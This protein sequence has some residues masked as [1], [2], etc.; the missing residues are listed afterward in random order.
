MDVIN[1]LKVNTGQSG[2][3]AI[4]SFGIAVLL[5]VGLVFL[6]GKLILAYQDAQEIKQKIHTMETSLKEWNDKAETVNRA[7]LRPV[8][9][10]QVDKIQSEI[11]LSVQGHQLNLTGVKTVTVEKKNS[12]HMK[13]FELV[14]RGPYE[15]TVQF[16]QDF[17]SRNVLITMDSLDLKPDKGEIESSVKYTIY[18]K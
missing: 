13:S 15:K 18:T 10:S 9:A 1:V 5:V 3:S 6:S 16:L 14:T 17:G 8:D 12:N 11:I 2:R 4:I 7:P